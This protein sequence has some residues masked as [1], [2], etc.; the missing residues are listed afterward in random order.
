MIEGIDYY[1]KKRNKKLKLK[2]WILLIL[3]F[4]ISI[5]WYLNQKYDTK[6]IKEA[7]ILII[8]SKGEKEQKEIT[9]TVIID[10]HSSLDSDSN[11]KIINP[12]ALDEAIYN[13]IKKN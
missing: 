12:K 3:A 10:N 5:F 13:Y 8:I 6:K 9:S 7:P 11:K 1:P 4:M 2:W